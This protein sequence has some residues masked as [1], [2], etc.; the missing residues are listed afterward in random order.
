MDALTN[1]T[2]GFLVGHAAEYAKKERYRPVPW[3]GQ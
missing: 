1:A 2:T 3:T